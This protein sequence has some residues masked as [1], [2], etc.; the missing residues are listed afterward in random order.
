MVEVLLKCL[1]F[2]GYLCTFK[3][4]AG[5]KNNKTL[6]DGGGAGAA[7]KLLPFTLP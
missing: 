3:N 5:K 1:P 4:K 7:G 6:Q 2:L